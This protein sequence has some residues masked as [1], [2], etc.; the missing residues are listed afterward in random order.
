MLT[1]AWSA[2]IEHGAFSAGTRFLPRMRTAARKNSPV[3][4]MENPFLL[5]TLKALFYNRKFVFTELVSDLETVNL[6]QNFL[7]RSNFFQAIP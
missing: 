5:F 4:S 7:Q 1:E 6:E 3:N 2:L